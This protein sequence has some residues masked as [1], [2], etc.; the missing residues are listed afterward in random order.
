M[1]RRLLGFLRSPSTSFSIWSIERPSGAAH[2]R[3]CLP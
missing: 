3:H 1:W 2:D